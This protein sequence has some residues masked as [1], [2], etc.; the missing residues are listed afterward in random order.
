M[1]K[2]G[3]YNTRFDWHTVELQKN[4]TSGEKE[5]VYSHSSYLWGS[6]DELS[7]SK[8]LAYGSQG[9]SVD[10]E[11]RL[12]NFPAVGFEDRLID[13]DG[14]KYRIDGVRNGDNE[15]IIT[16]SREKERNQ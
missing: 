9:S 2:A 10:C 15:T 5:R 1:N 16:A 4:Y 11:I 14:F 3:N 7:A 6:I 12:R 8:K 13:P